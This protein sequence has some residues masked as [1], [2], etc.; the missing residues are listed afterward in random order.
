M[1]KLETYFVDNANDPVGI[2]V[3]PPI[4]I[5]NLETQTEHII[6]KEY[7]KH[8][9]LTKILG[10][11]GMPNYKVLGNGSDA[12]FNDFISWARWLEKQPPGYYELKVETG[13]FHSNFTGE[14]MEITNKNIK[15]LK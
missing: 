9:S 8:D 3:T 14:P 15:I 2:K 4:K 5:Y 13:T 7:S 11:G 1:K 6:T 10:H 12:D